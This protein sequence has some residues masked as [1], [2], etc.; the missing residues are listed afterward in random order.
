[1]EKRIVAV[2]IDKVQ[3]LLFEVIHAQEKQTENATL[4]NVMRTSH[5]IS[6]DFHRK[7]KEVFNVEDKDELISCS[8]VLIFSCSLPVDEIEK[9]LSDLY[10]Q[11]Y[12]E[13]QG[14]KMVKFV[15]FR[16]QSEDDVKNI[17]K[18]FFLLSRFINRLR[19]KKMTKNL[20]H[21]L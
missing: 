7:I 18:F 14:Q 6:T 11:Y 3:T 19:R 20:I 17:G 5:D 8:G 9:R 16:P 2:S 12:C 4:K 21:F 13:S 10:I 15:H 1:M